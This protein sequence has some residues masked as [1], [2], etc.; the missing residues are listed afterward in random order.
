MK[1]NELDKR[2]KEWAAQNRPAEAAL[3]DLEAK[4]RGALAAEP[5]PAEVRRGSAVFRGTAPLWLAAAAALALLLGGVRHLAPRRPAEFPVARG[6]GSAA[7]ADFTPEQIA[8]RRDI[9][10]EMESLFAGQ[11][12]WVRL[13]ADGLRLGLAPPAS[14]AEPQAQRLAVRTVI[15]AR[16]LDQKDWRTVWSSDVLTTAEEYVQSAAESGA[17]GGLEM[18]VHRLPDGRYVVD[19]EIDWPEGRLTRAYETQV[20][21]AGKPERILTQTAEG[22]EYRVYQSIEPL[23]NGNG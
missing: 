16:A 4:I 1:T 6:N 11:V 22:R 19:A 10:D 5:P 3:A 15:V 7:P 14:A 23:A 2:L 20:L 21:S 17:A 18:W 8:A 9:L 12:R 13:D